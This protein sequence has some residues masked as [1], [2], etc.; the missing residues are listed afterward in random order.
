M[1]S[2]TNSENSNYPDSFHGNII[3]IFNSMYFASTIENSQREKIVMEHKKHKETTH[4]VDKTGLQFLLY[5][6]FLNLFTFFIKA[7]FNSTY[8]K[9]WQSELVKSD[10][11][12]CSS[13]KGPLISLLQERIFPWT[14]NYF[15]DSD[16]NRKCICF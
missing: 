4:L 15:C 1:F 6:M 12:S 16:P 7:V 14:V 2:V 3:L 5:I 10:F 8:N 9:L 11:G 13:L